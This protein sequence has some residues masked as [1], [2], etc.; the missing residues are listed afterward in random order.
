MKNHP[1]ILA[2]LLL[3]MAGF[4]G[5]SACSGG[6]AGANR[7]APVAKKTPPPPP[8]KVYLTDGG[9]EMTVQVSAENIRRRP[10]GEKLGSLKKGDKITVVKRIGNW[11]QFK[12]MAF[13]DA[14]IWAPSI[15]YRYENLYSPFFYFDTTRSTFRSVE[16]F[17]NMFSQRGQRRHED[18]QHFE[19]FFKDLGLGSH[20]MVVLDVATASEQLVEHGV[21]LFVDKNARQIDRVRVDYFRPVNGIKNVMTKSELPNV[22]PSETNDGHIIWH[23][24]TMIPG[25]GIDLERK[26]WRSEWF[27][28][29]WFIRAA[30]R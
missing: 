27:S 14:Y 10:N 9:K 16:Y 4:G 20:E 18:D 21:T 11:V 23:S 26:E 12:N 15:G 3:L 25:L 1:Y 8:E 13:T 29:I 19:L 6:A 22:Q 5:F 28:S 2:V 24:G 7:M 30:K 17:R